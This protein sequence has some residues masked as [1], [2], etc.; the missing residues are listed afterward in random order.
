V[1]N[2]ERPAMLSHSEAPRRRTVHRGLKSAAVRF[3][4][5][6]VGT[7]RIHLTRS[8]SCATFDD[9]S[10]VIVCCVRYCVVRAT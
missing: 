8:G 7:E 1:P 4:I 2:R 6:A 5:E 10:N 9:P 3:E